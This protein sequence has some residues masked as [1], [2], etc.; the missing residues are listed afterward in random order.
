MKEINL[1][2]AYS[3]DTAKNIEIAIGIAKLI[4][5][6]HYPHLLCVI[7]FVENRMKE[8][9]IVFDLEKSELKK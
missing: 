5:H 2:R 7:G 3:E 9:E 8:T 1:H 4:A 6:E